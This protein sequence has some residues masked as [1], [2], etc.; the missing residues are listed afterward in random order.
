MDIL[1]TWNCSHIANAET[2]IKLYKYNRDN[3]LK[4]PIICTPDELIKGGI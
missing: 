3:N 4:F 1:L 2:K